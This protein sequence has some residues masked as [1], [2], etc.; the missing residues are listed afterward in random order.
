MSSL[1][2]ECAATVKHDCGTAAQHDC[3]TTA[4]HDCEVSLAKA[5]LTGPRRIVL[6]KGTTGTWSL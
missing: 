4:N 6:T 3:A 1:K 5:R 2:Y